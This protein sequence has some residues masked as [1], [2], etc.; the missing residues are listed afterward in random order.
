MLKTKK[1]AALAAILAGILLLLAVAFPRPIKLLRSLAVHD[2]PVSI[3]YSGYWYSRSMSYLGM[4]KKSL[5]VKDY[6][7]EMEDITVVLIIG[8][9]ARADRFHCFGYGRRTTPNLDMMKAALYPDAMSNS[10]HTRWAVPRMLTRES[11]GNL[12]GALQEESIISF[13]RVM[14]FH[15][16]WLSNHRYL[17]ERH[18]TPITSFAMESD[19]TFF[20]N[21]IRA[22]DK[23]S[24]RLDNELLPALDSVIRT[25]KNRQFIVIH[26]IGSSRSYDAHYNA[27]SRLFTPVLEDEDPNTAYN[28]ALDNS[29]DNTIVY[30]DYFISEV[31]LRLQNH[32]A[33]VFYISDHGEMLDSPRNNDSTAKRREEL[34]VPFV[35]WASETYKKE[36]PGKYERLMDNRKRP[37]LHDFVFHSI[38]DGAGIKSPIINS[39]LS[40]FR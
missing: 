38:L 15:T 19:Y 3:V 34:H 11:S 8:S 35:V 20:N 27:N 5:P 16:A 12:T 37:V 36:N 17:S 13:L 6:I 32:N 18:L 22:D 21:Q 28:T 26:T 25:K 30:A 10:M 29:Y 1:K 14:G 40:I 31:V 24:K 39:K 23:Q 33:L 7:A 4:K 9:Y 2:L